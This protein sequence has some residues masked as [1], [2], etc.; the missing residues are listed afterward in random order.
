MQTNSPHDPQSWADDK[1][2]EELVDLEA[3]E[4]LGSWEDLLTA[5]E[6][7]V[8]SIT[9]A[10]PVSAPAE[11]GSEPEAPETIGE[12]SPAI[13]EDISAE[14]FGVNADANL[15]APDEAIEGKPTAEAVV[16]EVTAVPSQDSPDVAISSDRTVWSE[17]AEVLE[18]EEAAAVVWELPSN[19]TVPV[20][21]PTDF[22][23]QVTAS[24]VPQESPESA[25]GVEPLPYKTA[26]PSEDVALTSVASCEIILPQF[27]T[28]G[29][30]LQ[31]VNPNQIFF[32]CSLITARDDKIVEDPQN[33]ED[34][35]QI[36][37]QT[38]LP[39]DPQPL[40]M[41]DERDVLQTFKAT[42]VSH[43]WKDFLVPPEPQPGPLT[44]VE[45]ALE[46]ALPAEDGTK[47][48]DSV[49][50]GEAPY[51]MKEDVTSEVKVY[52]EVTEEEPATESV[53]TMWAEGRAVVGEVTEVFTEVSSEDAIPAEET[54][55]SE[56]TEV[57]EVEEAATVIYEITA[58]EA[59]GNSVA[60]V[61]ALA[62]PH[63]S[64]EPGETASL[65]FTVNDPILIK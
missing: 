49:A 45:P 42:E 43:S 57:Q 46:V 4:V 22:A 18:I 32:C 37:V 1:V 30:E 54:I 52:S 56:P 23:A 64:S 29:I 11:V 51:S 60:P 7:H 19:L 38:Q 15:K 33:S 17:S 6:P 59:S 28:S 53:L 14:T 13:E 27:I 25:E 16:E 44:S 41:D 63:E 39:D 48:Q 50:L 58:E 5:L 36:P 3:Q 34:Q 12:A 21:T 2:D 24:S 65:F 55:A 40:G 26:A 20:E 31:V 10:T 61:T 8:Q 35:M 47:T 62:A 9:P